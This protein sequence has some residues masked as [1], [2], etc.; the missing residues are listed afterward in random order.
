MAAHGPGR[1][2]RF[3]QSQVVEYL[4]DSPLVLG[5]YSKLN[6]PRLVPAEV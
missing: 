4:H 6:L 3:S 2:G 5:H 1:L